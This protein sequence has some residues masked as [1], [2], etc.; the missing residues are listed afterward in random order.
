MRPVRVLCEL[1]RI[2]ESRVAFRIAG[3]AAATDSRP[4]SDRRVEI[5]AHVQPRREDAERYIRK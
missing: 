2:E 4:G 5:K 1:P 3:P